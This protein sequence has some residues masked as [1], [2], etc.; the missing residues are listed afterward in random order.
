[1]INER[2]VNFKFSQVNLDN[3]GIMQFG[4]FLNLV[5]NKILERENNRSYD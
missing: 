3:N 4:P 2:T 1:M 5:H